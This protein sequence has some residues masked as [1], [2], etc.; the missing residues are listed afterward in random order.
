MVMI[1]NCA[2]ARGRTANSHAVY[3]TDLERSRAKIL[4]RDP[5]RI[6]QNCRCLKDVKYLGHMGRIVRWVD[7]ARNS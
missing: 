1:V 7:C 4:F 5:S 2:A 3:V 6:R